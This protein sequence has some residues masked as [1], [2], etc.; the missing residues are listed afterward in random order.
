[1]KC[2]N[3]FFNVTNDIFDDMKKELG[4]RLLLILILTF[5][6]FCKSFSQNA[7][8]GVVCDKGNEPIIGASVMVKGTTNG[9]ITD[10]NG[11]F[12]LNNVS[13]KDVLIVSF[14]GY[15]TM[16]IP[17]GDQ[18]VLTATLLEDLQTLDE[19]VVVGF[20]TQ[21]K[22]NL[23]G[24]VSTISSKELANRNVPSAAN[25]I[26][27]LDPAINI[28]LGTGSPD[29]DYS[30]N[31]RGA[32]SINSSSPLI[33]VDGVEASLKAVNPND[34][35]SISILKD[36]SA[37]SIYGAKASAGVILVT[38]KSGSN[39][40]GKAKINYSGRFSIAN[41]TTSN[42]FITVGY[43]HVT[44]VNRFYK[45]YNGYDNYL[46]KESD[47]SLQKLLD[48][49]N[50][51]TENPARPWVE[52][53]DDGKYYYYANFDWY[54]YLYKKN[55]PQ[56][57]H[58]V[59]ISGGTEKIKYYISG[60]YLNQT[61]IFKIFGDKYK[62]FSF[63]GK[64][65][66]QIMPKIKYSLN[67]SYDWSEMTY[68]GKS[69]YEATIGALYPNLSPAFLPTNPDG[70]IV[71]YTNQH[72]DGSPLGTGMI[73][74]MTA[75]N[76]WNSK[77]KEYI[78][79]SNQFDVQLLDEL[80]LTTS[81]GY[82][83]RN[84][85]NKYR[86]N[87]VEYSRELDVFKTYKS[88]SVEN[89]Y[90]E[91]R[92]K[93]REGSLE[94]YATYTDSYGK[95][96]KH[97][98][99]AVAGLQYIDFRYSTI[100][101]K[102]YDL[103]S[104]KLAS[105]AVGTGEIE[106]SQT[107]NTLKTL[108]VFAR[109]NYDYDGKY[110]LEL[111]V[112]ADG[113]SRF[114]KDNRWGIFP[115]ASAGWRISQENFFEPLRDIWN[116][117][118]V[119]LS[120]GSLGNQQVS[121][122]YTYIDQINIDNTMK[123]TFD[124]S[125]LANYA[126]ISAPIAS[127]LTW[128]TVSTY[129]FGFDFG[130]FNNRLSFN[131][132]FYIRETKDMLTPGLTLPDVFGAATPKENSA[133]LRTNGYEIYLKWQD[134]IKL[135]G[136]PLYYSVAAT[137]GD[138]ITKITKFNNPNRILTDYYVGMKLGEI[139]GYRVDGL[140][141]T[142]AEAAEYQA[143]IYDKLV[144]KRIYDSKGAGENRLYAGDVKFR[145]LDGNKIIDEG[146]GTVDKPGDKEIIGNSLPRYTYSFRGELNWNNFDFSIFFQG[147]GKRDW[148]PMAGNTSGVSAWDFWGPYSRSSTGFIHKDFESMCYSVDNPNGYF[149]RQRGYQAYSNGA[150]GVINDRYLQNV[151]YLRLKNLSLGY[152]FNFKNKVIQSIRLGVSGDNLWYW[153]PLKKYCKT[154]DPEM[155]VTA[156]THVNNSGVGY[157]I[158]SVYSFNLD[159]KF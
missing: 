61:G 35:E 89:S 74:Q 50:D 7:I 114:A 48:R 106:L 11:E 143:T 41:N 109:A 37:A 78:I 80:K 20:G 141:K 108:G 5:V 91:N 24:A 100:Q 137:F 155:A 42:D 81:Y 101:A 26:Q 99:N 57:E 71:C 113:S 44:L 1:M 45:S 34:I 104:E 84:P 10:L 28:D 64:L 60:R 134:E 46:F 38:T 62:N 63:R 124:D 77:V 55:R 105:L 30:I 95:N 86:N 128:E 127:N 47:G 136:K 51:A 17:V 117:F 126:K 107:I 12:T 147:V 43:D 31:I 157:A 23:T 93:E 92:Y 88:G 123:Y 40:E 111:S 19:V 103:T 18:K 76:S 29:S 33:L 27:G 59:S 142:D 3:Y 96:K 133:D 14:I 56:Q 148:Y 153:S 152:T 112:R 70:S 52:V 90:T 115:S 131:T 118:K 98:F 132:D 4:K 94:V 39:T 159:I 13:K 49:R 79:I 110:L 65:N 58:N 66:A 16:E 82:K 149:P 87:E 119:R 121:G 69:S 36:A 144:N 97:N 146:A 139:W 25:A 85:L 120:V 22:R 130:L 116:N 8:K 156:G 154:M 67:V 125:G 9:T 68:P 2:P 122:Y 158:S 21:K 6:A 15:K 151:S 140:F 145:D 53:G 135:A 73:C 129:N 75:N 138:N 32:V 102:R 54:N 83:M 150:L 72:Y